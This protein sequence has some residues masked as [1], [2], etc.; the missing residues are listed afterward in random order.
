MDP[1]GFYGRR[2]R[3]WPT[4]LVAVLVAV[5]LGVGLLLW[6]PWKPPPPS[7]GP[8][9][10][11]LTGIVEIAQGGPDIT[12][13]LAAYW[14]AKLSGVDIPVAFQPPEGFYPYQIPD[15][16]TSRCP[17][18]YFD[19]NNA[20]YCQ[21]DH[22]IFWDADWF[23]ELDR[24]FGAVAPLS[25]LAHEYGHHI[26]DLFLNLAGTG[27]SYSKQE[28][29]QADCFA[30]M[31][32]REANK[33]LGLSNR[34]LVLEAF[35]L[36]KSADPKSDEPWFASGRHGSG[37]ER[38]GALTR[39]FLF[40]SLKRCQSYQNYHG[41]LVVNVGRY[42]MA[43]TPGTKID[44]IDEDNVRVTNAMGQTTDVSYLRRDN[45]SP[46][47][48]FERFVKNLSKFGDDI[49]DVQFTLVG[50]RQHSPHVY[51]SQWKQRYDLSFVR[52][53]QRQSFHGVACLI[54]LEEVEKGD[55]A[56]G[57]DAFE[58]GSARKAA[59]TSW[60]AMERQ[61]SDLQAGIWPQ[62]EEG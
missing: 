42:P 4:V 33:K 35:E 13:S 6:E 30:G 21:R 32:L 7:D 9:P 46:P 38:L 61:I 41:D 16:P 23:D 56:I 60:K 15:L 51:G 26:S 12:G 57:F 14:K 19:R 62:Q 39:G 49:S 48:I 43:I 11:T 55:E 31:Y 17:H 25:V 47:E 58:P 18:K 2:R 59:K 1:R 24:L 37:M 8:D 34:Q 53:G 52:A 28:E 50:N 54:V 3:R 27:P 36:Y 5:A 44:R 29:L 22:K 45:E 20:M 10:A 40:N